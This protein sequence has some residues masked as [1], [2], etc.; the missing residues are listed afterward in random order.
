LRWEEKRKKV[1]M[2]LQK[3]IKTFLKKIK[4]S[5]E[6]FQDLEHNLR[7]QPLSYKSNLFNL[8]ST[9]KRKMNSKIF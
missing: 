9:R 5:K 7:I 4:S 3:N 8:V 1:L 6:F 2:K